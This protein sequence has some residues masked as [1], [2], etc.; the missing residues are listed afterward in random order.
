MLTLLTHRRLPCLGLFASAVT[1]ILAADPYPKAWIGWAIACALLSVATLA[2]PSSFLALITCFSLFGFVHSE[3]LC[4]DPGWL[5]SIQ[6]DLSKSE[7]DL[8]LIIQ[9]EP[10]PDLYHGTQKFLA[11]VICIDKKS[12]NFL[13][14]TE[15]GAQDLQYGD[16]LVTEGKLF[17]FKRILNPG[18]FDFGNYERR[19]NVFLSYRATHGSQIVSRN[20]GNRLVAAA[21][22]FRHRF[23]AILE[24]GLQDDSEVAQTIN[25]MI[26]GAR[27]ETS[28]D[29]K[30]LF[31]ETG[32]IHLFAASG[33][34]VALF[35][36]IWMKV[37]RRI[38]I[39]R[40][41]WSAGLI[42]IVIGYAAV[43]GFHS[44]TVRACIMAIVFSVGISLE[45][46][47]S[48]INSLMVTGL[49]I[50]LY[51]TQQLF[52]IGFQLS[53]SAVFAI[54]IAV[55]PL[56]HWLS[57]PF[58]IDPFLPRQLWTRVQII[59]NGSVN[60]TCE[61]VSLSV[62]CWC[63]TAPVLLWHEHHFS[64]ISILANVLVVPMASLVM[65]LAACALVG[66]ALAS[67][68]VTY[69]NNTCWLI[70]K[71]I[72]LVLREL[73]AIPYH[74]LNAGALT[75]SNGELITALAEGKSHVI[76]I[77][78][79]NQ[80]CLFNTGTTSQW[81]YV[82]LP[83]LQFEGINSLHNLLISTEN[84]GRGVPLSEAQQDLNIRQ[85]S[86]LSTRITSNQQSATESTVSDTKIMIPNFALIQSGQTPEELSLGFKGF[87]VDI[88][89]FE[90]L[91]TE[92]LDWNL[93]K[94]IAGRQIDLAICFHLSKKTP[95]LAQ[96]INE[97]G[98]RAVVIDGAKAPSGARSL[99]ADNVTWFYPE[100]DGAVTASLEHGDLLIRS[101]T[102]PQ[103]LLHNRS[104]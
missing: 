23:A 101:F 20:Q 93:V 82:T 75:V 16:Q 27:A 52:Q 25:G 22:A 65:T 66:S 59:R 5:L 97:L 17:G 54:V 84:K 99:K 92:E 34:Q 39:A 98:I 10:S 88:G 2:W 73:A 67:W 6:P 28:T 31:Q 38:G 78:L 48:A 35:T 24:T 72:L 79:K 1:G 62:I 104:R 69:L 53:F 13:A 83:Y 18:E 11:Q 49:V 56:A 95:K 87:I 45:R 76:H 74:C 71:I 40:K 70:T 94:Q 57:R 68:S 81:R 4:S 102:G 96:F 77:H 21:L 3:H 89:N 103:T 12:T 8:T 55:R 44:A 58:A 19:Q 37:I 43:T 9:S 41:W 61:I 46:A 15:C 29:L 60:Q 85:V 91:I 86:T 32:T 100:R 64:T 30:R 14:A 80:D 26:L 33:L 90:V 42:P 63:A 7:H 50:L 51:D 47:A 36:G